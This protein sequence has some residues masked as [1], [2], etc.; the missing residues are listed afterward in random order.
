MSLTSEI[1]TAKFYFAYGSDL[2]LKRMRKNC[3]RSP[4]Y[5]LGI[6]RD[7]KWIIGER[8]YANVVACPRGSA[9]PSTKNDGAGSGDQTPSSSSSS[10]S[11]GL[12]TPSSTALSDSIAHMNLGGENADDDAVVYG[13]LYA[14]HYRDEK[15]LDCIEDVPYCYAKHIMDIEI[16]SVDPTPSSAS[17]TQQVSNTNNENQSSIRKVQ[18][19]VYVD[20]RPGTG[21]IEGLF[22]NTM[23]RGITDALAKGM[24]REY[25]KNCLR[26][27]ISGS[28]SEGDER[29]GKI[30]ELEEVTR[31][32]AE[33]KSYL[34][35]VPEWPTRT[36]WQ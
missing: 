7:W 16:V 26:Y 31:S 8:G 20:E 5:A 15:I 11:A 6:L 23:N 4:Y 22:I 28:D 33:G 12:D 1:T 27:W 14:L 25:V 2:C 9:A 10:S 13:M 19:L 32:I 21:D 35:E 34:P 17:A 29:D 36:E 18:A 30:K 24:P 3:P